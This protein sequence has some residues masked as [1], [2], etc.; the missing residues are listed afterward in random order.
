MTTPSRFTS[1]G[2]F[3]DADFP[4]SRD[5]ETIS[6]IFVV[7]SLFTSHAGVAGVVPPTITVISDGI[8][9]IFSPLREPAWKLSTVNPLSP[10]AIAVN[11]TE[12]SVPCLLISPL[13]SCT[14]CKPVILPVALPI[15]PAAK[16]V[17]PPPCFRKSPS[18]T[19]SALRT[20]LLNT[21]SVCQPAK[22]S[23]F[24]AFRCTVKVSPTS[25]CVV[26]VEKV[27][28]ILGWNTSYFASGA[29]PKK[30]LNPP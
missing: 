2:E 19:L 11:L 8:A 1:D 6:R 20:A 13:E 25:T 28:L 18:F 5:T 9:R 15:V 22:S 29:N 7:P 30:P 21:I 3:K 4:K 16:K 23:T 27:K 10:L 24:S 26:S 17:R 14:A 12:S